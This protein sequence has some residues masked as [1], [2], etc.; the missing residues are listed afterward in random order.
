MLRNHSILLRHYEYYLNTNKKLRMLLVKVVLKRFQNKYGMRIP[1]NVFEKGLLIAHVAPVTVNEKAVVG[2]DAA[3]YSN[4]GIVI[5]D[6]KAPVIGK[7]CV[8]L[9]GAVVVGDVILGN[10][11]RIGA[12]AV[13]TKSFNED[14]ITLVG[15]PARKL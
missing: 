10:D 3:L 1:A 12:N 7:H 13:V 4:T 6:E 2:E 8:I 15:V 14:G 11:V 9:M 5:D